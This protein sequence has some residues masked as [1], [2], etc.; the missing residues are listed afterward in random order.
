MPTDAEPE[1]PVALDYAAARVEPDGPPAV[2]RGDLI[3]V[4]RG[5][6]LPP[7]CVAT[8]RS[9]SEAEAAGTRLVPITMSF[10]RHVWPIVAA[11]VLCL[12][13]MPVVVVAALLIILID[14][15]VRVRGWACVGVKRWN[16]AIGVLSMAMM[17]IGMMLCSASVVIGFGALGSRAETD[18]VAVLLAVWLI[19][20]AI[21]LGAMAIPGEPLRRAGR[22]D[23]GGLLLTNAPRALLDALPRDPT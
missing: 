10:D 15:P 13:C 11:T 7:L 20:M 23:S 16:D 3:A 14:R 4:V 8:G 9:A 2:R 22:T 19:G 5:S 21:L 17:C 1:P 18:G 6:R 12:G